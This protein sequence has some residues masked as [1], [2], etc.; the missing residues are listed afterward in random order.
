MV[1]SHINRLNTRSKTFGRSHFDCWNF[2]IGVE[3][4]RDIMSCEVN[5]YQ[6]TTEMIGKSS[7]LEKQNNSRELLDWLHTL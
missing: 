2:E 3:N 5:K 6:Q 1:Y 4:D 7:F